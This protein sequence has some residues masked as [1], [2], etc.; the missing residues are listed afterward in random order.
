MQIIQIILP[1]R[2]R[3][4][5]AVAGAALIAGLGGLII[6]RSTSDQP[7]AV[8]EAEEGEGEEHGP[9]GFIANVG[10]KNGGER[11]CN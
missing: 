1:D 11:D 4:M 6:G 3:W 2:N 10:R 5:A 8:A 7:V 9:E